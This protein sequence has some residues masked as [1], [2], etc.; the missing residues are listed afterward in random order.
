MKKI[1]FSTTLCLA[2]MLILVGCKSQPSSA[3]IEITNHTTN[4]EKFESTMAEVY[5][6]WGKL[7]CS[8]TSNEEW[9]TMNGTMYLDGK[10]MRT[11]L[12]WSAEGISFEMNTLTKDG[13]SYTRNNMNKEWRKMA[14]DA[15]NEVEEGLNDAAT[16][17]DMESLM[18]FQCTKGIET[19]SVFDIPSNIKFK[20]LQE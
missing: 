7:T 20:E 4:Q 14:F 19:S 3:I 1:L 18:S 16:D 12:K 11:N 13:Y 5:K 10:V 9:V 15:E 8:I 17:T 6:K 2:G